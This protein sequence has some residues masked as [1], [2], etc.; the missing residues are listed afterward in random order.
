MR[1][2]AAA[3]QSQLAEL[4]QQLEATRMELAERT[5][6]LEAASAELNTAGDSSSARVQQLEAQL[7]AV[8]EQLQDYEALKQA[9]TDVREEN[10]K[11]YNTVQVRGG[12]GRWCG[13]CTSY[14]KDASRVRKAGLAIVHVAAS[15]SRNLS[16]FLR[17]L[18][19]CRTS[20]AA[21]ACSA[22]CGRWAPPATAP[23]AAWTSGWRGSWRCTSARR[24][25]G[26]C[27]GK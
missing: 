15:R 17:F 5:A 22:A 1:A 12:L 24:T 27:T 18:V 11:L 19:P 8:G 23:T 25:A 7:A 21:S 10:K 9:F 14:C 20:R 2:Q 3:S 4:Q 26:P 16:C 6:A 13:G